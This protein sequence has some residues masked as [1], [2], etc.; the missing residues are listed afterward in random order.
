MKMSQKSNF[1]LIFSRKM[2]LAKT[3]WFSIEKCVLVFNI[4]WQFQKYSKINRK[5][6]LK[7]PLKKIKGNPKV[8]EANKSIVKKKNNE[9]WKMKIKK[10]KT[11]N[12]KRKRKMKN[13]KRK[14]EKS[15]KNWK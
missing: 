14:P 1:V 12:K 13:E 6:S 8:F 9:N 15:N 4:K 7:I 3:N 5:M 10:R 11:E 2:M